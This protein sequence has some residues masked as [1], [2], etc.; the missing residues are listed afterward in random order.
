MK[1]KLPFKPEMRELV[2]SGRKTATSRN[3]IY[4]NPDDTFDLDGITFE[5]TDLERHHLR[6]VAWKLCAQEGFKDPIGFIEYWQKIHPRK[7]YVASQ[8]VWVHFFRRIN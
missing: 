5:I 6:T 4:G 3:K 7:G 1:I 2:L 8:L